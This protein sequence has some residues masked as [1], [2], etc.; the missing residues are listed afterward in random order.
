M[1]Q[2]DGNDRVEAVLRGGGAGK[3]DEVALLDARQV[4]VLVGV[5]RQLERRGRRIC[6]Q[7]RDAEH[8]EGGRDQHGKQLGR[9]GDLR[10]YV[11]NVRS[12]LLNVR[13]SIF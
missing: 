6:G 13:K 4:G 3:L 9:L 1:G 8:N 10:P 7:R 5:D 2:C 11:G 12:L